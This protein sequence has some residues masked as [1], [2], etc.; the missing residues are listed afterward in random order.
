MDQK[1]IWN[2]R[3]SDA[4]KAYLFGTEPNQWLRERAGVW[5]PGQRVLCVA[6]GEGRNS[7]WLAGRGLVLAPMS[8]I[9]TDLTEGRLV[10]PFDH[11]LQLPQPYF[12]AWDRAALNTPFGREFHQWVMVAGRRQAAISSGDIPLSR[13]KGG[14]ANRP[15]SE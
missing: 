3:Y 8:M 7:V 5:T 13:L 12:L 10:L 11:R 9:T 4:G 15:A 6:D 1:D 14:A 2:K